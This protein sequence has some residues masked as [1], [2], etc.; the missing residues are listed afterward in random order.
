VIV[1]GRAPGARHKT[2]HAG[3]EVEVY[4]RG[5]YFALTG[6]AL[7][8]SPADIPERQAQLDELYRRVFTTGRGGRS[9]DS[10]D[11]ARPKGSAFKAKAHKARSSVWQKPLDQLSDE[12][13]LQLAREAKNGSKFAALF[14][15]GDTSGHD[16][17]DSR[18]DAALCTILA[19]WCGK[20]AARIDRLFRRSEL[21]R[22]KWDKVHSGE[23]A[24][25]GQM[26]VNFAVSVCADVYPGPQP[27]DSGG[28]GTGAPRRLAAAIILDYWRTLH[29]PTFRRGGGI[30]SVTLAREVKAGDLQGEPTSELIDLLTAAAEAVRNEDG[31]AIRSKLP[32]LFRTWAAVA[33]GDLRAALPDETAVAEIC[34]PARE[35]FRSRVGAALVDFVPLA[36]SYK[37]KDGGDRTEVQRRP[38][39]EWA[40]M[41]AKVGAWQS[42]RGYRLWS[43]VDGDPPTVRVA[44]RVELFS[45]AHIPELARLTQRRFSDLCLLYGVGDPC[46]VSGG[47]S[48]AVELD[49]SFL[50][51]L[52]AEPIVEAAA[53]ETTDGRT[54]GETHA[55]G[56][57]ENASAAPHV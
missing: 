24:T 9:A 25:Y 1:R 33:W 44:L 16:N 36:Y 26:T 20:D 18:A 27:E 11:E 34:D 55:G 51:G 30:Y 22:D 23:G 57:E 31:Q 21:M 35:E 6:A 37:A 29:R 39:L 17:D 56:R 48:R 5:R 41:F 15:R 13:I 40:K 54:D 50:R 8:G 12:D 14:D 32:Q 46:K 52:M 3:G 53:K 38:L 10:K 49:G 19:Y 42:V 2:A 7:P 43:R 45:Q 47:D 4:D 28:A